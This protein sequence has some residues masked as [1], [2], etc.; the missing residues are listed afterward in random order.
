MSAT[1]NGCSARSL[2]VW[3]CSCGRR[4]DLLRLRTDTAGSWDAELA[5]KSPV[6][7][8]LTMALTVE[9]VAIGAA[10]KRCYFART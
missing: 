1:L 10:G 5:P 3:Y 2:S 6:R 7:S 9:T 8:G 4:K